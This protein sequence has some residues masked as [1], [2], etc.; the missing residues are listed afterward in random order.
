MFVPERRSFPPGPPPTWPLTLQEKQ[1]LELVVQGQS[2]RKMASSLVVS[3]NT[4]ETHLRHMYEE[5]D[6]HSRN[7]LLARFFQEIYGHTSNFFPKDSDDIETF[8]QRM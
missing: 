4:V 1:V 8:I 3:E 2:N 6:V 7:E 5:L